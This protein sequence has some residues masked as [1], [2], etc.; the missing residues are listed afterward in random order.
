MK[1]CPKRR[2]S[3]PPFHT[4]KLCFWQTLR[5]CDFETNRHS[6]CSPRKKTPR[7]LGGQNLTCLLYHHNF[8]PTGMEPYLYFLLVVFNLQSKQPGHSA[9]ESCWWIFRL[10][11]QQSICFPRFFDALQ[12]EVDRQ[13]FHGSDGSRPRP[14]ISSFSRCHAVWWPVGCWTEKNLDQGNSS[15]KHRNM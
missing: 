9:N 15:G 13:T 4:F 10:K 7:P 5:V 12:E 11:A 6:S 3:L 14:M 1:F 8:C 2:L